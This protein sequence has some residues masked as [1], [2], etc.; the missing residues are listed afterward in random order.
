MADQIRL[1]YNIYAT[2][3]VKQISVAHDCK[4]HANVKVSHSEY[5]ILVRGYRILSISVLQFIQGK[6]PEFIEELSPIITFCLSFS[7]IQKFKIAGKPVSAKRAED[8]SQQGMGG[9]GGRG[10]KI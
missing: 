2:L 3:C 9:G 10:G 5:F 7:V 8:K 4:V 1:K 6:L